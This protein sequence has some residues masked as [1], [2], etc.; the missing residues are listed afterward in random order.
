[1]S[2]IMFVNTELLDGNKGHVEC[3][4]WVLKMVTFKS[5]NL[6][7]PAHW[8]MFGTNYVLCDML[9]FMYP[10]HA[11]YITISLYISWKKLVDFTGYWE[12]NYTL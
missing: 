11:S 3:E 1:M 8:Q 7:H 2:T 10:T 12:A 4:I 6:C 9:H 5:T